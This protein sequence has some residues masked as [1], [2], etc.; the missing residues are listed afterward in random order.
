MKKILGIFILLFIINVSATSGSINENSIFECN[1]KY[2]GSHGNPVHFHEVIKKENKWVINGGEVDVPSCYIKPINKKED[3]KFSKCVDGDTAKLIIND[4]E[5]TVR[6]LAIDTPEIKHGDNEGD[7]YGDK[8]SNF[9]CNKLKKAQKITLEYDS[10]SDTK[11]K[12]GRVLAFVFVDDVLLQKELIN[13]GLAKVYYVYGD[14][15]YVDEL[16]RVEENAKNNKIGIWSSDNNIE[17][18]VPDI[19][20]EKNNDEETDEDI[21]IKILNYLKIMIDYLRKI[22]DLLAN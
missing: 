15:N 12:Y 13:N 22:F 10:N 6:F 18:I 17:N 7:P 8:A 2:Y 16:R 19:K 20:E 21:F 3:A 4:K 9:T 11:D 5:E 14:Y 1:N